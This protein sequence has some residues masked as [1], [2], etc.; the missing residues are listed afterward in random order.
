MCLDTKTCT[1]LYKSLVL[2]V[3]DYCDVVY[4]TATKATLEKLQ[5]VQNIAYCILNAG[6]RESRK[7]MHETLNFLTLDDR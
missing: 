6:R 7:Y 1:T 4:M 2:L 3:L 5:K